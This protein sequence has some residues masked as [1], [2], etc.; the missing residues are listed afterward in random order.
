MPSLHLVPYGPPSAIALRDVL[1]AAKGD[2]ALAAV[3]VAVPSNYVGLSGRASCGWR[4][5]QD[6]VGA[7]W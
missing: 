4:I 3:T 2:D 5:R 6:K 1:I 7:D